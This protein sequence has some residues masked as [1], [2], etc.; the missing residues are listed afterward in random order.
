MCH[1]PRTAPATYNFVNSG[2]RSND[3]YSVWLQMYWF[4]RGV[5]LS[6][7][8]L[9]LTTCRESDVARSKQRSRFLPA[10]SREP[11]VRRVVGGITSQTSEWNADAFAFLSCLFSFSTVQS[12]V[13][14]HMSTS[15]TP[16]HPCDI[17]VFPV[18]GK[19]N[20]NVGYF[21]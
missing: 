3:C 18:A 10:D 16:R 4:L 8:A 14:P 21:F 19:S 9:R 17:P 7:K 6:R 12:L 11:I 20:F 1:F 13:R 5:F 15:R 2:H